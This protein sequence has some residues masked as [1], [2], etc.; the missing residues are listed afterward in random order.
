MFCDR[1]VRLRTMR[2]FHQKDLAKTLNVSLDTLRRWE[3]GRT[4][5]DVGML[6]KIAEHLGTTVAFLAE[7]TDIIER[8]TEVIGVP[9]S[10]KEALDGMAFVKKGDLMGNTNVLYYHGEDGKVFVMP[11]TPENQA[12]FREVMGNAIIASINNKKPAEVIGGT[13]C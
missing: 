9:S 2:G 8:S 13:K 5:P 6:G 7:E 10:E 12:W 11:A 4:S 3:Q 1:L